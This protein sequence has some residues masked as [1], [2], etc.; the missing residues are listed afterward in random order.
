[1][2]SELSKKFESTASPLID[3]HVRTPIRRSCRP[4]GVEKSEF[5]WMSHEGGHVQVV[6]EVDCEA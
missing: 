3:G 2:V 5:G 4:V 1:M 6:F